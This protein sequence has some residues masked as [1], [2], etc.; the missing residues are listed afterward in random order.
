MGQY[1]KLTDKLFLHE[2][3]EENIQTYIF[4]CPGC[5]EAHSYQVDSKPGSARWWKYDGNHESPTFSPSLLLKRN[6]SDYE[7]CGPRC[8]LFLKAGK[9]EFLGD[10]EHKLAGQTVDLPVYPGD[11]P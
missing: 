2:F 10:C 9:L 8:H 3:L 6:L 4:Y 1:I 11:G 7:G 5:E